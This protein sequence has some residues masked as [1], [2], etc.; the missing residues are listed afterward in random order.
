MN[1]GGVC[2]FSMSF[3]SL[4]ADGVPVGGGCERINYVHAC[5]HRERYFKILALET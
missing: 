4:N 3:G 5:F 1:H 2:L